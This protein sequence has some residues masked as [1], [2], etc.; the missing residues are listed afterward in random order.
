MVVVDFGGRIGGTAVA[1]EVV[2]DN[3]LR[4]KGIQ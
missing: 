3:Y 1:I 2:G 4:G